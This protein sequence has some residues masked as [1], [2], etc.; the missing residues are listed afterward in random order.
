MGRPDIVNG[1]DKSWPCVGRKTD[2]LWTAGTDGQ[3]KCMPN[4]V[5]KCAQKSS[6]WGSLDLLLGTDIGRM[7]IFHYRNKH[8][9]HAR[10]GLQIGS[11]QN[12]YVGSMQEKNWHPAGTGN[13]LLCDE[14]T[15]W[16]DRLILHTEQNLN[17]L[18]TGNHTFEYTQPVKR[19]IMILIS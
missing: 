6:A 10:V 11:S 1:L 4:T 16:L 15:S 17:F 14:N 9:Q 7:R 18:L 8:Y 3:A 19:M 12:R 13:L 5:S 2:R